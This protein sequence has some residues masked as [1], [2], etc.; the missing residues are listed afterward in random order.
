M[1]SFKKHIF[2]L[3]IENDLV[4]KWVGAQPYCEQMEVTNGTYRQ[5]AMGSL[6]CIN[7]Q[8]AFVFAQ[9]VVIYTISSATTIGAGEVLYSDQACTAPYNTYSHVDLGAMGEGYSVWKVLDTGALSGD[10]SEIG[11]IC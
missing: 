2:S 7:G 8:I 3:F 5:I 11:T 9:N 10:I 6:G 4:P 1:H